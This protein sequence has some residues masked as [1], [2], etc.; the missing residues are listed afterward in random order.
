MLAQQ[1]QGPLHVARNL[2]DDQ[3]RAL[4][5][6]GGVAHV[7]LY[8]GFLR[9]DGE[10]TVMDAI[11]HLEHAI[12]IMGIDHVGLGTDFDGDGT[13]RGCADASELINFHPP[14]AAPE[15]QRARTSRR[16]GAATGCA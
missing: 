9:K 10:A 13:V 12:S 1:Q 16:S 6:K 5:R 15:I 2:T 11:D 7:T 4:A 8:H 14:S 3:L